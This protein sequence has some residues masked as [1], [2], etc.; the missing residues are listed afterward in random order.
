ML[1]IINAI[2]KEKEAEKAATDSVGTTTIV[3]VPSQPSLP[4]PEPK[5]EPEAKKEIPHWS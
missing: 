3:V 2:K 5:K 1:K 4:Q